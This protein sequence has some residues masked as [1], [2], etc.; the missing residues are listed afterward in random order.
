LPLFNTTA[1]SPPQR[2]TIYGT[3]VRKAIKPDGTCS[4]SLDELR[5]LVQAEFDKLTGLMGEQR[6]FLLRVEKKL[7]EEEILR[8]EREAK[9]QAYELSING[10]RSAISIL[11]TLIGFA[12]PKLGQEVNVIGNS[13]IQIA[14]SMTKFADAAVKLSG[15]ALGLSGAIMAGNVLGAV[16]NIV[17]LF[18][19]PQDSP[20]QMILEGIG[21]LR[22]QVSMLR[23][24]MHDRFD[25]ID[26]GLNKIYL[27]MQ[28]RFEEVKATLVDLQDR[29]IEIQQELGDIDD[30]L[31]NLT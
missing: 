25:R 15:V 17:A 13:F 8:Q 1:T 7:E 23:T 5:Q 4:I 29:V 16:M 11:S 14:D 9:A 18:N 12:D 31:D 3:V 10:A 21:K 22:E 2:E 24:E 20:E 28:S 19:Q 27:D 6:E 26:K 30:E